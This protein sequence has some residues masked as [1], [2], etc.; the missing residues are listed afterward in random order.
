MIK[1]TIVCPNCGKTKTFE[2]KCPSHY[3]RQFCNRS[4]GST[5]CNLKSWADPEVKARR[6]EGIRR[7]HQTP[8]TKAKIK[9]SW[10]PGRRAGAS[11][12]AKDTLKQKIHKPGSMPKMR[13][14]KRDEEH[15]ELARQQ[16]FE[17]WTD[18]EFKA[19]RIEDIQELAQTE[20]YRLASSKGALAGW[21]DN[22]ERREAQG[23]RARAM[24]QDPDKR[25][26]MCISMKEAANQPESV[27]RHKK[28]MDEL[29]SDPEY[30]I[31]QIAKMAKGLDQKPTK[32]EIKLFQLL[33]ENNYPYIY[34]GDG[35]L[36]IGRKNPDFIWP[37][38][39]LL[40]EMF[41]MYWHEKSEINPRTAYFANYGFKMLV[42]W[43]YEL[44]DTESLLAKLK[45]FHQGIK[46]IEYCDNIVQNGAIE[47][48]TSP[49]T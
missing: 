13:A 35:S 39:H 26:G 48:Q 47:A 43:D 6:S 41:G 32:P 11:Q 36:R 23:N 38:Q 34:I 37:Q 5:Y 30:A 8:E 10:T 12:R 9:A 2:K 16:A 15:R 44:D 21:K 29:W 3:E 42:I 18:P 33:N 20:E 25:A 4:C 45:E 27:A 17:R 14:T 40:I 22:P 28:R 49:L 19:K 46:L 7:A 1:Y 31:Q 24:W